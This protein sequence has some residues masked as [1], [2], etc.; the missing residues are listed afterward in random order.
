MASIAHVMYVLPHP[1]ENVIIILFT[2]DPIQPTV[3]KCTRSSRAF[4]TIVFNGFFS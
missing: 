2:V 1:T 4:D 3:L